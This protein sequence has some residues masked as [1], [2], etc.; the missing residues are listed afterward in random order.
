MAI[1]GGIMKNLKGKTALVTGASRGIGR[2]IAKGIAM[3]GCDVIIHASRVEN[4]DETESLL[5]PYGVKVYKIGCDLGNPEA[6][7]EMLATIDRL[8]PRVGVVY[9]NA[10]ISCDGQHP[11]KLD[12]ELMDRIMEVNLYSMITICNHFLPKMHEAGFGR[13]VNVTSG[14][15]NNPALEPYSISKAAVSKYTVDM[16]SV[17]GGN[18][19]MNLM[20]PDWVRTDMGGQGAPLGVESLLP[21]VLVPLLLDEGGPCGKLFVAPDYRNL[22]MPEA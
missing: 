10:G 3:I 15:G 7:V 1:I 11:Y 8:Y 4:L 18:V 14:A 13:I 12:R 20:T 9:N 2:E 16:A 19:L 17:L 21:G 6:L 5:A 22:G